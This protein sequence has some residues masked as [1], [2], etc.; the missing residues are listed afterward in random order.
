MSTNATISFS[1][2][3][4][5]PGMVVFVLLV[6]SCTHPFFAGMCL[7]GMSHQWNLGNHGAAC[8][9]AGTAL[10][11]TAALGVMF[12]LLL[13]Y[14][15]GRIRLTLIDARITVHKCL[16]GLRKK[17]QDIRLGKQSRFRLIAQEVLSHSL[18]PGAPASQQVF[19]VGHADDRRY[20]ALMQFSDRDKARAF[21]GLLH[22]HYPGIPADENGWPVNFSET[23]RQ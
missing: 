23:E 21:L 12:L 16:L 15:L 1:L 9:F 14:L 13:Y 19:E 10:L 7:R 5:V 6:L 4:T 2:R 3:R 18:A 11:V 22:R 8:I 20:D 17:A